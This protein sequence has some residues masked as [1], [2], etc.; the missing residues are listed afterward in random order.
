MN[1]F[2]LKNLGDGGLM[3]QG[4]AAELP[5]TTDTNV[6]FTPAT[7][8]FIF[9][10][11]ILLSQL[12]W[13]SWWKSHLRLQQFFHHLIINTYSITLYLF[14][15][16]LISIIMMRVPFTTAILFFIFVHY[17]IIYYYHKFMKSNDTVPINDWN[18]KSC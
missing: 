5:V 14:F 16:S 13:L 2:S 15:H 4:R 18:A 9:L 7:L 17:L 11:F 1:L 10:F 3:S 8:F 6:P 12:L